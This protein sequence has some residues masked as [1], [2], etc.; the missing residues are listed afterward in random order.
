MPCHLSMTA[1]TGGRELLR[2]LRG[3]DQGMWASV[4]M[5]QFRLIP[6]DYS[7][8]EHGFWIGISMQ[9]RLALFLLWFP[10]LP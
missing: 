4:K 5:L 3:L 9:L 8:L 1:D 7:Y 2:E 10:H 6:S